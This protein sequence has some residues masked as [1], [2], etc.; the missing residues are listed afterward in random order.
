MGAEKFED[1]YTKTLKEFSL[2]LEPFMLAVEELGKENADLITAEGTLFYVFRKLKEMET[3]I[4]QEL[5]ERLKTQIEER[6]QQEII[7]LLLF[8]LPKKLQ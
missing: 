3:Q 8:N 5:F 7:T 2:V 6:R 1:E 4:S